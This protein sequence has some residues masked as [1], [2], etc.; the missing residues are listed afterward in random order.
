MVRI[1]AKCPE[2]GAKEF[3]RDPEGFKCK[4]C[5]LVSNPEDLV[6]DAEE[7]T[8][9]VE[10][11]DGIPDASAGTVLVRAINVFG[12]KA[13]FPA[14]PSAPFNGIW[15]TNDRTKQ[16]NP[17]KKDRTV[18]TAW[19]IT[20]FTSM[21]KVPNE[22]MNGITPPAPWQPGKPDEAGLEVLVCAKS[23]DDGSYSVFPA[24]LGHSIM[25]QWCT[26]DETKMTGEGLTLLSRS[27]EV[28]CWQP[29][30]RR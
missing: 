26:S 7:I 9:S 4:A 30:P 16:N 14:T 18:S 1:M 23:R 20:G 25:N 5:A 29:M 10:W 22:V 19:D 3:I 8:E 28:V 12:Q 17:K 2:C 27:W 21:P 24:F 13:I 15:Y 6:L 11:R